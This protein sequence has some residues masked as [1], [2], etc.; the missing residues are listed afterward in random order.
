MPGRPWPFASD[1]APD[2]LGRLLHRLGASPPRGELGNPYYPSVSFPGPLSVATL[3]RLTKVVLIVSR[4]RLP[5]PAA[6]GSR[7][8]RLGPLGAISELRGCVLTVIN[9][10]FSVFAHLRRRPSPVPGVFSSTLLPGFTGPGSSVLPVDLSPSA[11]SPPWVLLC[12]S[13][14]YGLRR[15]PGPQSSRASLGKAHRLPTCRPALHQVGIPDIG[16]RSLT[17]AR[18]RP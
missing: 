14:F 17:T 6:N 13:V 7:R 1:R 4:L 5:T 8:I 12:G 18:P 16:S 10:G 2:N 3:N 9:G 11:P 15:Q